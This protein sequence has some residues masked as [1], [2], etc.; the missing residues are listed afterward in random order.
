MPALLNAC[1]DRPTQTERPGRSIACFAPGA[2]GPAQCALEVTTDR[3]GLVLTVR[4]PDGGF[5]RFIWPDDQP[6]RTADGAESADVT[7]IPGG[8]DV[9]VG[10]WRY[11]LETGKTGRP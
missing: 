3:D 10:G 1:G 5:R 8:V 6:L 2:S 9:M 11:R 4:H 7:A